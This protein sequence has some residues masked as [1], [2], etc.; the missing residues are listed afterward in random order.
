[1]KDRLVQ[2]LLSL[3]SKTQVCTSMRWRDAKKSK[4]LY[5]LKKLGFYKQLGRF[6]YEKN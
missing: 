6:I 4:L 1:M 2:K 5:T 3:P